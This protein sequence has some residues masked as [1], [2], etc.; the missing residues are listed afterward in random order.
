MH[1]V[2][3]LYKFVILEDFNELRQP[4][5]DKC[6]ELGIKGTL[7]LAHEGINGTIAGSRVAINDILA[8]LKADARLTEL[9]H[10]M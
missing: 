3:A 7:L 9:E 8:Y 10:P 4:L 1:L 5:L 6:N 2:A